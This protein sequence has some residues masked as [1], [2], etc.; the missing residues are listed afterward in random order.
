MSAS[1]AA[2]AASCASTTSNSFSRSL[3]P[4]S[5][6]ALALSSTKM[7]RCKG[8]PVPIMLAGLAGKGEQ[9]EKRRSMAV[10]SFDQAQIQ[11][12]VT[13]LGTGTMGQGIAQVTAMSGFATRMFD[14]QAGRAEQAV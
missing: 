3:S 1:S 9:I 5:A 7:M 6:R 13:V 14:A 12:V 4:M 2:A 10:T 11:D 8:V